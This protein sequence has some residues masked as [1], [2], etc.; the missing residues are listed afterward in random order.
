[1]RSKPIGSEGR[2]VNYDLLLQQVGPLTP[3]SYAKLTEAFSQA[4]RTSAP[5]EYGLLTTTYGKE[6]L[7]EIM[8]DF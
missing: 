3:E 4:L 6:K 2:F 7:A 1:M 8:G 5:E